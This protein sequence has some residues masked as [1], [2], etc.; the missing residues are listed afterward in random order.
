MPNATPI[1]SLSKSSTP[2]SAIETEKTQAVTTEQLET[3]K[4]KTLIEAGVD[5]AIALRMDE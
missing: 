1:P 3:E 4:S 2:I 5:P